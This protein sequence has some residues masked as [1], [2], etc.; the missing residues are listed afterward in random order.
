M[1]DFATKSTIQE[2]D[3]NGTLL[4]QIT[5]KTNFGYLE[6]RATLYGPPPR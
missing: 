6:K 3:A 5:T 1:V 4:Q 2:V